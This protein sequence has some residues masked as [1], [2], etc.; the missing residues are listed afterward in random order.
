MLASPHFGLHLPFWAILPIALAVACLFG[1]LLGRPRSS[2]AATT[3]P[4]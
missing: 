4:S 2:C 3:W 1:V